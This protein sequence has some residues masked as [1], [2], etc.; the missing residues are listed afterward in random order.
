MRLTESGSFF[1]LFSGVADRLIRVWTWICCAARW[2]RSYSLA[3]PAAAE[4][5]VRLFG[6]GGFVTFGGPTINQS[7]AVAGRPSRRPLLFAGGGAFA[8]AAI[9]HRARFG[10][11]NLALALVVAILPISEMM[12]MMV[13][14]LFVLLVLVAQPRPRRRRS[15]GS[16]WRHICQPIDTGSGNS[17]APLLLLLLRLLV[18]LLSRER[19]SEQTN[20][21]NSDERRRS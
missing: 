21:D 14:L 6:A 8:R 4:A 19:A 7:V 9:D 1:V 18:L 16:R 13:L 12:M 11:N 5:S 17:S 2:R 3:A 20:N 10:A 15:C